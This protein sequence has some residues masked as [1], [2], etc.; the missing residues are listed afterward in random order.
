MT[1]NLYVYWFIS[2]TLITQD[3]NRTLSEVKLRMN[4]GDQSFLPL[5]KERNEIICININ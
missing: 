5:D 2:N 4:R 1:E 3:L